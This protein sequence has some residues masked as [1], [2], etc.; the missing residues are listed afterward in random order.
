MGRTELA[1]T[2]GAIKAQG[3]SSRVLSQKIKLA[4]T[5]LQPH[6][7]LRVTGGGRVWRPWLIFLGIAPC[8]ARRVG[9]SRAGQLA[10]GSPAIAEAMQSG[11][12]RVI[13][14]ADRVSGHYRHYPR[15]YWCR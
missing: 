15:L 9:G 10:I 12:R 8:K 11:A 6:H 14:D 13:D 4:S 5:P 3:E 7:D 2:V 1:R